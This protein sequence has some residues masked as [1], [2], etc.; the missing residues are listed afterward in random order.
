MKHLRAPGR[1][2][3]GLAYVAP[4][5]QERRELSAEDQDRIAFD[6]LRWCYQERPRMGFVHRAE[7]REVIEQA[8][9]RKR[10]RCW[11]LGPVWGRLA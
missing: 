1:L 9:K 5:A 3:K 4:E 2:I 10:R 8:P 7:T 11:G 6:T